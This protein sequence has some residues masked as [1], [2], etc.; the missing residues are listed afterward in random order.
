M[1]GCRCPVLA[2][3][4]GDRPLGQPLIAAA[5]RPLGRDRDGQRADRASSATPVTT[6]RRSNTLTRLPTARTPGVRRRRLPQRRAWTN[7]RWWAVSW[8]VCARS[9]MSRVRDIAETVLGGAAAAVAFALTG[10]FIVLMLAGG[11]Y[12]TECTRPGGWHSE[13]WALGG[14]LPYLWNPG[15]GCRATALGRIALGEIGVM[16]E[17]E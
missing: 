12:K 8:R 7:V 5:V 2:G 4:V 6:S 3:G 11:V 10:A 13:G 1:R 16:S 9:A 15:E 14:S 17:V